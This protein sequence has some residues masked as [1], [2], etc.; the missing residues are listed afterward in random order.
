MSIKKDRKQTIQQLSETVVQLIEQFQLAPEFF[1]K[2]R[3]FRIQY[4]WTSMAPMS[5]EQKLAGKIIDTKSINPGSNE[6]WS[7]LQKALVQIIDSGTSSKKFENKTSLRYNHLEIF[8]DGK[9]RIFQEAQN[10]ASMSQLEHT[11]IVI[12]FFVDKV[13]PI[14]DLAN[15]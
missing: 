10:V 12:K 4:S 11:K 5:K 3:I 15:I 8:I 6:F 13:P 9:N 14:I 1:Q 2:N 7:Q